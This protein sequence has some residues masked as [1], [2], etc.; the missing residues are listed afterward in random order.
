MTKDDLKNQLEKILFSD[1]S[2]FWLDLYRKKY[3][4][5]VNDIAAWDLIQD[6]PEDEDENAWLLLQTI[7]FLRYEI[8][9][10]QQKIEKL[11]TDYLLFIKRLSHGEIKAEREF[12]ILDYAKQ[13]G[14]TAEELKE[15]KLAFNRWFDE[16]AVI[17]RYQDSVAEIEQTLKFLI[18]K[19]G[20]LTNNYIKNHATKAEDAWIKLD[21]ENFIS[22]L[23]DKSDNDHL[24]NGLYRALANQVQ[25]MYS[26]DIAPELSADL[27]A[28]LVLSLELEQTP[29]DAKIDILE[30]LVLQ[31]PTFIQG[32]IQT[33]IE[34]STEHTLTP[35]THSKL[36]FLLSAF[37]AILTK[38]PQ[39]TSST[40][41]ILLQL[42]QHPFDRV[43]QS[44]YEQAIHYSFKFLVQLLHFG[45]QTEKEDAVRF[46]IFK[47]LTLAKL[48]QDNVAFNSWKSALQSNECFEI[49]RLLLELSTRIMFNQQ[50]ES[51]D[52]EL[53]F[54]QYI[55][56]LNDQLEH[57]KNLAV[58]RII[59]RTREQLFCFMH[60]N[61]MAEFDSALLTDS[62]MTMS[63]S[64]IDEQLLGRILSRK[65]QQ[66]S[67]F[68][69]SS[70]SK[71][72][73]ITHGYQF[74]F[75][76]W[77]FWHEWRNPSSDKRQSYNH[78]KARK[79]S[80][81]M[82]VPSST[83]AEISE[84]NVPGEPFFHS[85]EFS[86]RTHLPL[87]D[88][89]LSV[90]SQ[91][92]IKGDAK[93]YTPDGILCVTPPK[94][95]LKRLKVYFWLSMNYAR[96][97][98]L[99]KSNAI[100][101][102][103]YLEE[104]KG[105]GFK[106]TF[107]SYGDQLNS[108]FPVESSISALYQRLSITPLIANIWLSFKEYLYS[109]YQNTIGQLVFFVTAF[110]LYFW[111]RHIHAS[112]RIRNDRK[113]IP[114]SIG[115][116]GTRGKS[117][118]ERLKAALFSSLA[119]KSV[120]KT[121]GCEATLIY[122]RSNGEQFE[123][124]IFRPFDKATIWEQSDVLHFA[125]NV[126]ADVFLWEC[127]GLTPRYVKILRTW[128][129]DNFSTITNAYPDHED[130]L[131]PTGVDVA[132]EMA[133]F[134]PPKSL[135]FT[136]EQNMAPI[137]ELDAHQ[138]Q[139]NLIQVHWGDGFQITSDIRAL[140]PYEEHPDNIALVCKMAE[141][142]G[143]NKDYVFKETAK[144]I[145]P[146]IGVLQHF[147]A[148]KIEDSS[149]SFVNSMSANERLAT[150]ENWRRLDLFSLS[151]QPDK[152]I[153]ALINNRNDRVSRS[154]VFAQI[155]AHDLPF[156]KMVVIGTNID[157]FY[158]YYLQAVEKRI[159]KILVNNDS[160]EF[161]VL[162]NQL[163][164][165]DK[166]QLRA[167]YNYAL[168]DIDSDVLVNELLE[169]TQP[170]T[171]LKQHAPNLTTVRYNALAQKLEHYNYSQQIKILEDDLLSN[172][173][174]IT[175]LLLAFIKSKVVLV[176]ETNINPDEL[177]SRI[178]DLATP[179]CHQVVVGMQNIKG[180]GL[181]YV[182]TWQQWQDVYQ[183]VETLLNP[184]SS[185]H[186]FKKQL[187]K[188]S[189]VSNYSLLGVNFISDSIDEIKKATHAQNEFSQTEILKISEKIALTKSKQSSTY[190]NS[191][192]NVFTRFITQV[193]ESFLEAGAAIKRKKVANQVYQDIAQQRITLEKA[194]EVLAKLNRNQKPGW[195]SL[196]NKK[197]NNPID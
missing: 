105:Q 61:H 43:R 108:S 162:C 70:N 78:I 88:F 107:N 169:S 8:E 54:N 117:G 32:Y 183:S 101:Q 173:D 58:K 159:E 97:D 109:I 76:L 167:I 153:I 121:T 81:F 46:T 111:G 182:Y 179:H 15:D 118:T 23:L 192:S 146:D 12:H 155:L 18:G 135:V 1:I 14:A 129:Q 29:H 152:Q 25:L 139:S 27:I 164:L 93:T 42:A 45:L 80:A 74:G 21:L 94:S 143:I 193:I 145:V 2:S 110:I 166:Q 174:V 96:L 36:L 158:S 124:P 69:V 114:V 4:Q 3:S 49:K 22:Q 142:I 41:Q 177:T 65:A 20:D 72:W 63:K 104:L 175:A 191:T 197:D 52:Y 55:T 184:Q 84:T 102:T 83:V 156:D 125:K 141:H 150:L 51:E 98:A 149:I 189:L 171:V 147:N 128:M 71:H 130:I 134:I 144:R 119:L 122:A 157:G 16:G 26:L 19:L 37:P 10:K 82:H 53:I 100:E 64:I 172:K 137:L 62:Q 138:K 154:K 136:S 180:V 186:E 126:K 161:S 35:H 31:R 75:R 9:T 34:L 127:M 68:N 38:T 151:N 163:Q 131:G 30:I 87:L 112:R 187:L 188:L 103:H 39:L 185:S 190:K 50:V 48:T 33:Q 56:I 170:H 44:V 92:N 47:Q 165:I 160:Q 24:R 120:T 99:R 178:V 168:P 113:H 176:E 132:S 79:P 5:L 89:L 90:L 85:E 194:I 133:N 28:S 195:L 17:N 11:D 123:I 60:Q 181:N 57:E 73:H 77:R 7:A 6:M 91:D 148:A 196:N 95:T 140:Y 66:H 115:G 67:G 40:E 86:T 106:F 59:T 13:L 116:W